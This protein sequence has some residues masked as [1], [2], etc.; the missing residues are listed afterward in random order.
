MVLYI[1]RANG[2]TTVA[3]LVDELQAVDKGEKQGKVCARLFVDRRVLL[4]AFP[5][6]S[7]SCLHNNNDNNNDDNNNQGGGSRPPPSP[8]PQPNPVVSPR[9]AGAAVS[10]AAQVSPR[11]SAPATI[12]GPG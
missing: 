3:K 8:R 1:S 2:E 7:S 5:S 9:S 10:A 11:K 4:M 6:C 12:P